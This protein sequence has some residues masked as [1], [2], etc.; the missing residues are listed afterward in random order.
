MYGGVKPKIH[1]FITLA[2]EAS[3]Q[4]QTLA[5]YHQGKSSEFPLDTRLSE[6]Q[7]QP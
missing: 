2:T 7:S 6:L 3:S 4:L 1:V 5:D